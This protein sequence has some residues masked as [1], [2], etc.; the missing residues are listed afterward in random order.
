MTL[1]TFFR[2][3]CCLPQVDFI[4][5]TLDLATHQDELGTSKL[6]Q[7]TKAKCLDHWFLAHSGM[8]LLMFL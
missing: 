7:R 1:S 8:L 5:A 2:D 3:T 4:H 6:K